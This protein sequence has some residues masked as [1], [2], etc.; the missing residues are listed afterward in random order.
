VGLA[1]E[2]P[3]ARLTISQ[4]DTALS[5]HINRSL[6]FGDLALA[7]ILLLLRLG[8]LKGAVGF[9]LLALL[10]PVLLSGLLVVIRVVVVVCSS[11]AVFGRAG[12]FFGSLTRLASFLL[13]LS[14]L[15]LEFEAAGYVGLCGGP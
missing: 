15:L 9:P 13:P 7:L 8:T 6:R 3:R 2:R 14:L 4:D 5:L 10:V 12:C 11:L 1:S